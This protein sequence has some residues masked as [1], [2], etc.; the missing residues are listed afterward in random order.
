MIVLACKNSLRLFMFKCLFGTPQRTFGN[1]VCQFSCNNCKV[2]ILNYHIIHGIFIF[3]ALCQ[4]KKW[5]DRLQF[6]LV[7]SCVLSRIMYNQMN[8]QVDCTLSSVF[9]WFQWK[10]FT[11][12][13]VIWLIEQCFLM[14][15]ALLLKF[16][17]ITSYSGLR[18]DIRQEQYF[19]GLPCQIR[20]LI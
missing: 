16:Y 15:P 5:K 14:K 4:K 20:W 9:K 11:V 3:S 13:A 17:Y 2:S 18:N 19:W 12:T 1:C 6:N 8:Q 10:I 7:N